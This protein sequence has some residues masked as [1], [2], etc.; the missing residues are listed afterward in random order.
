LG[1]PPEPDVHLDGEIIARREI[2][3][4]RE[5]NPKQFSEL[6]AKCLEALKRYV[7]EAENMC[8]LFSQCLA[9]PA[10]LRILSKIIEQRV[11]ENN[12]HASYLE[13]RQQLFQAVRI[14]YDTSH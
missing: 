1:G 11:R 8:E 12:A 14:S 7:H 4:A 10:S 5:M 3:K 6:H 13:I 9:E 2:F